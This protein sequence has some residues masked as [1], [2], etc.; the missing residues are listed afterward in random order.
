MLVGVET[1]TPPSPPPAPHAS[2]EYTPSEYTPS[3]LVPPYPPTLT[4]PPYAA[5]TLGEELL[6]VMV[7][8]FDVT[9]LMSVESIITEVDALLTSKL[10]L[11]TPR[12]VKVGC[13]R[14]LG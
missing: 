14:P 1:R 6:K 11:I 4:L 5:P 2:S 10:E 9:D 8:R 7:E 13:A 12:M 3:E